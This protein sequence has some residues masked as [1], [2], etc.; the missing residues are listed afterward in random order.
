MRH[1]RERERESNPR[2][3]GT[4]APQI[5]L[6]SALDSYPKQNFERLSKSQKR[7][8]YI[9]HIFSD[10]FSV[11][12]RTKFASLAQKLSQIYPCEIH[13]HICESALFSGLPTLNGN[14][15]TYFRFF[16]PRFMPKDCKVCL[17]LDIDMLVVGDL[18]GLWTL[19]MGE[20]IVGVVKDYILNNAIKKRPA[21]LPKTTDLPNIRFTGLH[22]NAGFMLINLEA[23]ERENITKKCFEV[24]KNYH[25]DMHDQ[26]TLNAVIVEQNRLKLPFAFNCLPR[27]FLQ[28]ICN[29]ESQHFKFDYTRESM[30]LSL[31]NPMILHFAGEY[32][33][34]SNARIMNQNGRIL[35]D[36]WWEVALNTPNF[37]EILRVDL[38][39]LN[40]SKI[41]ETRVAVYLLGFTRNFWGFFALPFV[42]Q[43]IFGN[44]ARE[45]LTTHKL[46]DSRSLNPRDYNF[47]FEIFALAQ[48]SWHRRKKGDL[49]ILPFKAMKLKYRH[50]RYGIANI[51]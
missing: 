1:E 19:K 10:Y 24:M 9:F 22:F 12:S 26:D 48:K 45:V 20:S 8:G 42:A 3:I 7:E 11:D 14:Y 28:S 38:A 23:W 17:Y 13:I 49:L 6:E 16:I 41:Y 47:A 50:K 36:L 2:E 37:D 43:K 5:T 30:N 21:L 4:F 35:S 32:K 27:A 44:N 40:A 25:L 51:L 31:K 46:Q 29:D 39:N 18:R 15:L 33:S 34:W